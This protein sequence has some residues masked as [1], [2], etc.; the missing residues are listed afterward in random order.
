MNVLFLC[1]Y[2]VGRSQ[3]AE[4]AYN[5]LGKGHATSAGLGD[6]VKVGTPVHE[7]IQRC[8][9]EKGYDL[10]SHVRK[11]LTKD[12][13]TTI[14]YVVLLA[15][16]EEMTSQSEKDRWDSVFHQFEDDKVLYLPV[17]DGKGKSYE[18]ICAMRDEVLEHVNMLAQHYLELL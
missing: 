1:K 11:Q 14:D 10:T 17:T 15:G 12:M 9:Q 13:L 2:N 7:I 8:M 5:K 3:I 16:E 18:T 4:A 6:D